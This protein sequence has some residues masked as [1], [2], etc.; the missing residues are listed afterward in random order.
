MTMTN[1]VTTMIK[2]VTSTTNLVTTMINLVTSTTNL[3]TSTI[4]LVA[5]TTN[6]GTTMSSYDMVL[7]NGIL[8]VS[9]SKS[10]KL[11]GISFESTG[12]SCIG[13]LSRMSSKLSV[14]YYFAVQI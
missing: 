14:I 7:N 13:L 2:L 11:T 10:F 5:I 8:K 6:L 3:V 4:N 9:S 1:L 12:M